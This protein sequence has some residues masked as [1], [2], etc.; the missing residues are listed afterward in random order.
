MKVLKTFNRQV[1]LVYQHA[2][3]LICDDYVY[4]FDERTS[5]MSLTQNLEQYDIT[6]AI[7][8]SDTILVCGH[9]DY[10]KMT[11][12]KWDTQKYNLLQRGNMAPKV[13]IYNDYPVK[14][15]R[16]DV[17]AEVPNEIYSIMGNS[18]YKLKLNGKDISL[19]ER[20]NVWGNKRMLIVDY[21]Q[22]DRTRILMFY[23]QYS[24]VI[25]IQKR[26]KLHKVDFKVEQQALVSPGNFDLNLLPV[27]IV[28]SDNGFDLCDIMKSGCKGSIRGS[29]DQ[30][31]EARTLG[32]IRM[33]EGAS[34]E[35]VYVFTRDK[36][37]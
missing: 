10:Q 15:L 29:D 34:S 37:G 4:L 30:L 35:S 7:S 6:G 23:V 27:I 25:D 16:K 33:R 8:I 13:N 9:R 20:T 17:F 24:L 5:T 18:L 26:E 3:R 31:L 19:S 2:D 12:W 11:I 32:Q 28:S 14:M 36:Q 22:L 1:K 21:K